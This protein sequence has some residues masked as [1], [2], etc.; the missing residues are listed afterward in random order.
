MKNGPQRLSE[1]ERDQLLQWLVQQVSQGEKSSE[2]TSRILTDRVGMGHELGGEIRNLIVDSDNI[3]R[4]MT[5]QHAKVLDC[6]HLVSSFSEVL[7]MCDFG[8]VICRKHE[9]YTCVKCRRIICHLEAEEKD[10]MPVCPECN[11]GNLMLMV[12]AVIGLIL[13]ALIMGGIQR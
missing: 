1:Y 9:F 2:T 10:G 7:G 13:L 8:H 4:V 6:G 12:I 5:Y 3:P 11:S